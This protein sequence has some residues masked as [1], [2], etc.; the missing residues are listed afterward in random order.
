MDFILNETY[1]INTIDRISLKKIKRIFGEADRTTVERGKDKNVS[2]EF[3][4]KEINL[5]IFYG[6]CYFK[7]GKAIDFETLDFVI[8]KLFLDKD[9]SIKSGDSLK[10]TVM[11][12]KEFCKK[13]S[14]DDRYI[15][16]KNHYEFK[17]LGLMITFYDTQGRKRIRNIHSGLPLK[18]GET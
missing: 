15:M 10:K 5:L 3:Y 8:E 16:E 7:D 11:K 4:Y 9:I 12:I 2:I 18:Y 6:I 13:Y 17:E 14:K 1:G